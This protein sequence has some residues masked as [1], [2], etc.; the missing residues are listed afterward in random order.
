MDDV[1]RRL[2][3]ELAAS[4]AGVVGLETD[5]A[6]VKAASESSN[7][8]D[9]HDP[10]G[11]TIAFERQQLTALLSRARRT[12]S[13]LAAALAKLDTGGYGICRHCGRPISPE[14]LEARPQALSCIACARAGRD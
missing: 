14:R 10:E 9:E 7:A 11:A 5:L 2:L 12:R 8:D 6:Q 4:R 1:R 13:E 3:D